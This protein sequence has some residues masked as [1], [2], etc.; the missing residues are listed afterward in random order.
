MDCMYTF[1]LWVLI[2]CIA[3]KHILIANTNGSP[4]HNESM[5]EI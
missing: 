5:R 2:N 4:E 1:F 3:Y